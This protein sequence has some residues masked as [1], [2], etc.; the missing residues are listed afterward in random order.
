LNKQIEEYVKKGYRVQTQTPSTAQLVKPKSF[1]LFWAFVW[2]LLFGF[3]LVIYLLHYVA[4][5]DKAIY[6]EVNE[7]GKVTVRK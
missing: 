2:F 1:S 7:E 6:I 5:K 3:G 4:K